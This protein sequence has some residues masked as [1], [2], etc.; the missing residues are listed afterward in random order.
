VQNGKGTDVPL[1]DLVTGLSGTMLAKSAAVPSVFKPV[2][3]L[4]WQIG[5]RSQA[6]AAFEAPEI[7]TL[8]RDLV[9]DGIGVSLAFLLSASEVVQ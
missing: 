2:E 5:Q 9:V 1:R 8:Q 6:E 4:Q 3:S 7:Q